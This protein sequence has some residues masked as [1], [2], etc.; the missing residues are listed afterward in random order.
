MSNIRK[1]VRLLWPS[2]GYMSWYNLMLNFIKQIPL[3]RPKLLI[4]K[5]LNHGETKHLYTIKGKQIISSTF[6]F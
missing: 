6:C 3:K 5:D 1:N 2:A 4:K